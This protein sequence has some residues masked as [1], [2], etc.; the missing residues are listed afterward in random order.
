M[1]VI[2]V[3]FCVH[4]PAGQGGGRSLDFRG[5]RERRGARSKASHERGN[6]ANQP[7]VRRR[8]PPTRDGESPRSVRV[9]ARD[10]ARSSAPFLFTSPRSLP[11]MN[12]SISPSMTAATPLVSTPVRWSFTIW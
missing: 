2:S 9:Y 3:R 8:A 7:P 4:T 10:Y 6:R 12:G 11:W 5:R 1:G